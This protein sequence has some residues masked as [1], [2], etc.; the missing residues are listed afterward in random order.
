MTWSAK[1]Y[2]DRIE[3]YQ[4][5]QLFASYNL[6]PESICLKCAHPTPWGICTMCDDLYGFNRIY[7]LGLYKGIRKQD[8]D[9]LTRHT[10]QLKINRTLAVPLGLA[11]S[12]VIINKYPELMTSDGLVPF[13]SHEDKIK[14]KG[15]NHS[16]LITEEVSNNIHKEIFDCLLQIK[17]FSQHTADRVTR[18]ENVEGAFKF[19]EIYSGRI[20]GKHLVLIDDIVTSGASISKCS[21]LLIDNGAKKVDVLILGRTE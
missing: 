12:T 20:S 3:I 14:A 18:F 19:N 17:N 8:E 6:L 11:L 7:S 10:F 4:N 13:P 16:A 5:N 2:Q 21:Q 9:I 15:F 1:Y